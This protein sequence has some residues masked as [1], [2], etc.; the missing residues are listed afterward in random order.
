M[1]N[2]YYVEFE[3]EY[4]NCT[5]DQSIA[6]IRT[7]VY[8]KDKPHV[9]RLLRR[10][11]QFANDYDDELP[12]LTQVILLDRAPQ[13]KNGGLAINWDRSWWLYQYDTNPDLFKATT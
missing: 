2:V 3:C 4:N 1:I 9:E 7:I 8:A 11:Y 10:W 13:R 5:G 12:N 6:A